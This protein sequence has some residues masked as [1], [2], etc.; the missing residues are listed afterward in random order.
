MEMHNFEHCCGA[1]E[2]GGLEKDP[3]AGLVELITDQSFDPSVPPAFFVFTDAA[4]RGFGVNGESLKDFIVERGLG[5]VYRT[6]TARNPSSGRQVAV[7]V[8]QVD[9][10][11]LASWWDKHPENPDRE[12]PE[13]E[14][15]VKGQPV[16]EWSASGGAKRRTRGK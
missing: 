12:E 1:K 4:S 5:Q 14:T 7:Y 8:W 3:E 2:L 6:N 10:G 16:E 9:Q 13:H 11:A 15:P